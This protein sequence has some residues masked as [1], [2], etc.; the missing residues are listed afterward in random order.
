MQHPAIITEEALKD[1]TGYS[2]R[3]DIE[4]CLQRQ[5]ILFWRGKEGR[6]WTTPLALVGQPPQDRRPVEF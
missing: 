2:R 5:G 3:A 6:L 4:R 1:A